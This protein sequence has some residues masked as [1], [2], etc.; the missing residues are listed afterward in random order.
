MPHSH[1]AGPTPLHPSRP[2]KSTYFFHTLQSVLYKYILKFLKS[3]Q[4][5]SLFEHF[6]AYVSSADLPKEW[7]AS[8]GVSRIEE[9]AFPSFLKK[10]KIYP[11]TVLQSTKCFTYEFNYSVCLGMKGR[12]FFVDLKN[13]TLLVTLTGHITLQILIF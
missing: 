3:F 11:I 9:G 1:M 5:V 6:S 13:H 12:V 10:N 2:Q 8:P 7:N 4:S